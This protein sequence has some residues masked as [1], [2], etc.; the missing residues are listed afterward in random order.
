MS[1]AQRCRG[2]SLRASASVR[3]PVRLSSSHGR[4]RHHARVGKR[5]DLS[6]LSLVHLLRRVSSSRRDGVHCSRLVVVFTHHSRSSHDRPLKCSLS[7]SLDSRALPGFIV[8]AAPSPC[9]APSLQQSTSSASSCHV[10]HAPLCLPAL[11]L[12]P[13]FT[14]FASR[15][16]VV[17]LAPP[18]QVEL[19]ELTQIDT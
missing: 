18:V 1:F 11:G 9:T 17:R 6:L 14:H 10:R 3:R 4:C 13:L 15:Y 19:P 16:N 7:T 8:L 5:S 12:A 2:V